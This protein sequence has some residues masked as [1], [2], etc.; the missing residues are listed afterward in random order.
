MVT[1]R[2]FHWLGR[3]RPHWLSCSVCGGTGW[4]RFHKGVQLL[5]STVCSDHVMSIRLL[6]SWHIWRK[7]IYK[8]IP[9]LQ[10]HQNFHFYSISIYIV[11]CKNPKLHFFI[12]SIGAPFC[13]PTHLPAIFTNSITRFFI[14]KTWLKNNCFLWFTETCL[15][16]DS[17]VIYIGNITYNGLITSSP[18]A[19]L[20]STTVLFD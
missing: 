18:V 8:K 15:K 9:V 6:S 13:P 17:V 4:D 20:P 11:G 14:W 7:I 10:V 3:V 1:G 16:S 2:C 5:F 19:S 12:I